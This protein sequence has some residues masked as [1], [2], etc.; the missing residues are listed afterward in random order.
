MTER[1]WITRAEPGAGE[2]AV[3]VATL[4]LEP[5][6]TPVLEVQRL[7]PLIDLINVKA[8]AF[9]SRNG[10][11]AFADLNPERALPAFCVGDATAQAARALGFEDVRS[12]AGDVSALA[13]LIAT[14]DPGLVLHAA[15]RHRAGDLGADLSA[16]SVPSALTLVYETKERLP[17]PLERE[18]LNGVAAVLVHSPRAATVIA[19]CSDL[20]K[21]ATIIAL[22]PACLAPLA[23]L[24]ARQR[25]A[26][27]PT[28]AAL[29]AA[30][31]VGL[32]KPAPP[33]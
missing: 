10:V 18:A 13:T 11:R 20:L 24:G 6:V 17:S 8:L 9:T 28:E 15:G 31:R 3:R 32:G 27:A 12:A 21:E 4:G 7:Y 16:R 14:V 33:G 22:S 5:I 19:T 2:T 30:I 26:D 1:V 29:L 23:G 25:A